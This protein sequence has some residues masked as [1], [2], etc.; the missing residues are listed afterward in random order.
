LE[1]VKPQWLRLPLALLIVNMRCEISQ[2]LRAFPPEKQKIFV[3]NLVS[4][5]LSLTFRA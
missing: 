1:E 2:K 4:S 3:V 5:L